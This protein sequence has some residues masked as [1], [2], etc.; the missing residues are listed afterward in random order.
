M[1]AVKAVKKEG[2]LFTNTDLEF[3]NEGTDLFGDTLYI[4]YGAADSLIAAASVSLSALLIYT[5]KDGK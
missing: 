4:Y 5:Y 1:I 3:E 2:V